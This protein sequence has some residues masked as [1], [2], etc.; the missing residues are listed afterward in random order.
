ML[1]PAQLAALEATAAAWEHRRESQCQLAMAGIYF[2]AGLLVRFEVP[3]GPRN[4]AR[5]Q[6]RSLIAGFVENCGL[7]T[8]VGPPPQPGD[9]L[10]FRLGCTL[11]HVAIQLGG[12]RLVH[13]FAPHGVLIAPCIPAA[14]LKR[15]EKIWRPHVLV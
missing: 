11:H 12:G 15:L 3:R 2:D 14:W 1:T 5:A 9:L 4:W 10:G 7:F 6:G 8:A 13:V